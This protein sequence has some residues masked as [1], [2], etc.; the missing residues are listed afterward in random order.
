MKNKIIIEI[1]ARHI[2]LCQKDLESIFG[3]GYELKKLKHLSLTGEFAAKETLG[4]QIGKRILS[5]VRIIGPIRKETQVELSHTD[6]V[7]LRIHAPV[8]KSGDIRNTPGA[9][10]IGPKKKIKI[11]HGLINAWRHI[12][13][14]PK[15]AQKLGFKNGML[16]SVKTNGICS[17]TFHNVRVEVGESYN[18][19]M[20]LDTDEGNAACIL[21][22]GK[23]TIVK[24]NFSD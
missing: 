21:K 3:K 7:L 9:V 15:E 14:N 16:V 5:G 24:N 4:I 1:S 12:H 11:R 22:N 13:C 10:L 19:C 2:H 18:L 23:G 17:I 20:H 8:R 6:A